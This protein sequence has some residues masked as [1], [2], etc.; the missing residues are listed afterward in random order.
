MTYSIDDVRTKNIFSTPTS[1]AQ[2]DNASFIDP[3]N[4]EEGGK[5]LGDVSSKAIKRK[6][7]N[8][9]SFNETYI[10]ISFRTNLHLI[11]SNKS[12]NL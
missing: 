7:S 9:Y 6:H 12:T 1:S 4:P 10:F 8:K 3:L 2:G 11:L 5:I